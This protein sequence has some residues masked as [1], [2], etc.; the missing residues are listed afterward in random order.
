VWG[1]QVTDSAVVVVPVVGVVI[2]L[3]VVVVFGAFTACCGQFPFQC[4]QVG[5]RGVVLD[6]PRLL[7]RFRLLTATPHQRDPLNVVSVQPADTV[8]RGFAC[9]MKW[10]VPSRLT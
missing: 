6:L 3:T 7:G 9:W 2:P 5:V 10:L 4:R 1:A 8:C